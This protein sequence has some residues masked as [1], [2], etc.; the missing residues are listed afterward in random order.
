MKK[1]FPALLF[2]VISLNGFGQTTAHFTNAMKAE[3]R[4]K[5]IAACRH[6]WMGYKDYAWGYDDLQPLTKNGKNWYKQSLFMTP[7]DAYDCFVL[8]GMKKEAEEAKHI[9]ITS[10]NFNVDD[11]VQVF[12]ITIRMLGGLQ[13]AYELNGD[14]RFLL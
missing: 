5:V 3:M 6:A 12:E 9:I 14:R 4:S 8:L 2:L 13:S 10:L 1:I 7:V 11:E